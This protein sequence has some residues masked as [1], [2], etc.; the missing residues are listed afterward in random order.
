MAAYPTGDFVIKSE[1]KTAGFVPAL[2][3]DEIIASYKRSLVAANLFRRMNFK[4]KKGD[5]VTFPAPV[6]AT[7]TAKTAETAVNLIQETGTGIT[8]NI[9]SHWEYS[10]LIED[11]AETQALSSLR[12]FY[13]EDAGYALGLRVDT[14]LLALAAGAQTGSGAATYTAAVIGGNGSTLYT[15][16]AN[17]ATAL[18][19]AGIRRVIQTL[20]DFDVPMENRSLVVPPIV[21]NTLMGISRFTEQAFVGDGGTIRN[22]QIGDIY[23]TK[24]YVTT[25]C[26][27]A[28]GG[29]RICVMMH[30]EFGV[31]IEQLG[32]RVQTQ[33]KQEYLA[34]MLTA[35]TIY[36]VGELR[37]RSAVAIAVPAS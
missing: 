13:T 26:P 29:A 1:V 17:N 16:G 2:W 7:A 18:T 9:N 12:R 14:D 35:D 37:D 27:T 36:G 28:T 11:F 30:P 22:G 10:R 6:R 24:V 34:T 31:L 3:T 4:G 5:S 21:R 25:N 8:V 15:S 20:D 33:Y 19:D 32:V 23:G